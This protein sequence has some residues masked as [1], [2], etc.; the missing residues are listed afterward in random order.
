MNRWGSDRVLVG[1][2]PHASPKDFALALTKPTVGLPRL[3]KSEIVFT[4]TNF[5]K[6][7]P[8]NESQKAI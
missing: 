8:S 2:G 4:E 6:V 7:P 5:D 3:T 1:R